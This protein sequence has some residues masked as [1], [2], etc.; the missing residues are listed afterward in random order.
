MPGEKHAQLTVLRDRRT[1]LEEEREATLR[2]IEQASTRYKT[3]GDQ[4]TNTSLAIATL[5]SY[6]PH[7]RK[8]T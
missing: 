2:H 5:E 6:L 3:L 1:R 7:V 8:T 4:L